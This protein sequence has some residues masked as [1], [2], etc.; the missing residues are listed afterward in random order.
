MKKP[1]IAINLDIEQEGS[2]STYPHYV[3]RTQYS[4]AIEQAGA[5]VVFL[6]F[7]T[8]DNIKFFA[9]MCDGLLVPGGHFDIDPAMYGDTDLNLQTRFKNDRTNFEFNLIKAF[10]DNSKPIM[11]ICGG[12]QILNVF[13]GGSLIQDIATEIP[14]SLE[15]MQSERR[16]EAAHE[17]EIIN[18]TKLKELFSVN[19]ISVNTSHHQAIKRVANDFVVSA[20]SAADGVIEAFEHKNILSNNPKFHISGYQWHPEFLVQEQEKSIFVDFVNMCI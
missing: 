17:V 6:P 1:L 3:L 4:N 18:N 20:I 15:H 9:E 7:T 11:G 14:N 5:R 2:Y 12:M 10:H 13:F 19:K 8:H 16:D